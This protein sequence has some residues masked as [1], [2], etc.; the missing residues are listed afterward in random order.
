MSGQNEEEMRRQQEQQEEM[1]QQQI[2]NQGRQQPVGDAGFDGGT[3]QSI[4]GPV[5]INK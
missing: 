4:R 1:L 5:I 2:Q 3:E